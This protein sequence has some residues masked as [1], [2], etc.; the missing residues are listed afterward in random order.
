MPG[1]AQAAG[2]LDPAEALLDP[3]AQA[4][5]GGIAGW[6]VVR[7]SIAERREVFWATC[8]VTLMLRRS[9]TKSATS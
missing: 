3:L 6:R 2:G 8:G 5:A 9:A 7:R 4:L 1:L